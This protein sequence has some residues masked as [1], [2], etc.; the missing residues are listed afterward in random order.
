MLR[1]DRHAIARAMNQLQP[2]LIKIYALSAKDTVDML[3]FI[4]SVVSPWCLGIAALLSHI[5]EQGRTT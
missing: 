3:C 4:R 5:A 2:S 1:L